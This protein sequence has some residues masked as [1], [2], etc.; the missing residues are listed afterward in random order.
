M[1]RPPGSPETGARKSVERYSAALLRGGHE[2]AA[3]G[4]ETT[5][6]PP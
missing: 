3:N 6:S 2:D 4:R 5:K 1:F